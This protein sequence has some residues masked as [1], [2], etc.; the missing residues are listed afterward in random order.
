MKTV[1][2]KP[3]APVD[4]VNGVAVAD[5]VDVVIAGSGAAASVLAAVL[6]E[7]GKSV[8]LLEAGSERQPADM[9]SSQIWGRRMKWGGEPVLETGAHP[10]AY[11]FNMGRGTGGSAMHQ[12]AVWPRLHPEDFT[13]AT[14]H[15]VGLDWPLKYEDL[16]LHYDRVQ[17]EVGISGD[18]AAEHWRPEGAPYPMGPV[19]VFPQG[20]MI[21]RGFDKLK[22][23]TAPLPLAV[24]SRAYQGRAACLWDGWCDAGCPIGALANPMAVYL[25]RAQKA[26]AV[27][28]H[29]ATV[30]RVLTD[31]SDRRALGVEYVRADGERRRQRADLVVLA[32]NPIQN[33]R[34][35]FASKTRR[36]PT[37]L[38]NS[39]GRLGDYLMSHPTVSTFGLF[40]EKTGSYYGARGGQLLCQ[41][42]YRKDQHQG[43]AFGSYQWMIAQALKPNDLLGI[44]NSRPDLYGARLTEFMAHAAEHIAT[45]AAVCECLPLRENR[46]RLSA[47]SKDRF[48]VP[49]AEVSHAFAPSSLAL[50][51]VARQQGAAVFR[52]AGATEVWSSGVNAMHIMGGTVMGVAPDT[53]VTNS[54]GQTH[55]IPNLVVAGAGLF[56]TSGGVNPTFTLHALAQRSAE[57]LVRHWPV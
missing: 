24:N 3:D 20:R 41:D 42:G 55:D 17:Q 16:R 7:S 2:E 29:N 22:L 36:S 6:A 9:V 18:A 27:I 19:P 46:V 32:A 37:G 39:S 47:R 52:A 1:N 51:E 57:Y 4:G 44:V 10:V 43:D 53:S 34:I 13:L 45:M 25:P 56:P 21:A 12:Y 35:L 23:S 31:K 28:H 26:G 11:N 14:D 48:G 38:A 50:A 30:T 54:Y 33:P 5:V 49:L 8:L 40:A 15:G